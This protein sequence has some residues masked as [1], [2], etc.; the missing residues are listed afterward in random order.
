MKRPQ[1]L[2]GKMTSVGYNAKRPSLGVHT[3]ISD[4]GR[5]V[6]KLRDT[7]NGN[8]EVTTVAPLEQVQN[9]KLGLMITIPPCSPPTS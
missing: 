2:M 6:V 3:W 4:D 8:Y 7:G 1:T 9:H 5:T